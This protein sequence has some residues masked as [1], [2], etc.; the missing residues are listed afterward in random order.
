MGPVYLEGTA[1]N[2]Q[3]I[4]RVTNLGV[5]LSNHPDVIDRYKVYEIGMRETLTRLFKA[6]KKVLFVIDVPELG[7]NPR[8]CFDSSPI[9]TSSKKRILC[10]ISR[11]DYDNRSSKFKDMIYSIAKDFPELIV[12]DPTNDFCDAN[13]CYAS[14]QGVPLYRDFDHLNGYGSNFLIQKMTSQ[15]EMLK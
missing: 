7:F 3:D 5:H 13:Y 9:V 4:A 10:S 8:T 11:S 15:L 6:N 1:F 12:Y 2:G 14:I